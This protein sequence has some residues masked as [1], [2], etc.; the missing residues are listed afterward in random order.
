VGGVVSGGVV[1]VVTRTAIHSSAKSRLIELATSVTR[2][3]KVAS[4]SSDAAQAR[5]QVSAAPP[6]T[7]VVM[8]AVSV[9]VDWGSVQLAPPSRAPAPRAPPAA[10]GRPV[11]V[12][13][14]RVQPPL[15]ALPAAARR[16]AEPEVEEAVA[17]ARGARAR[18]RRGRP[19][20]V[21]HGAQVVVGLGVHGPG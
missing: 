6:R 20:V 4:A 18:G 9:G 5:P 12:A 21:V 7:K 10:L 17:V 8:V 11:R 16:H 1:P 14:A 2:T 15:G 3:R 19:A 13:G